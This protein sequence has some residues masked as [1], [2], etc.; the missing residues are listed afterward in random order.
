MQFSLGV[1]NFKNGDK[2]RGEFKDGR[3]CGTG[4]MNY[5]NSLCNQNGVIEEATYEGRWKGGH[6]EGY[7]AL[8][9]VDQ[10]S[11][12]GLWRYDQRL[13]GEQRLANGN[14]YEGK[15]LNDKMHGYGRLYLVGGAIFEGN[16][17]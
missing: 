2:Y 5:K 17:N 9:W 12:Q 8:N 7:G 13:E 11:Y 3:P 15:F 6:R 1:I 16:F 14:V 10:T 4:Q